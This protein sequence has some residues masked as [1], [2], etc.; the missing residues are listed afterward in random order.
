MNS[1]GDIGAGFSALGRAKGHS[2]GDDG[3][4]RERSCGDT[5]RD[6]S[7]ASPWRTL[8][9]RARLS[10]LYGHR[11]W[12]TI[13]RTVSLFAP[14]EHWRSEPLRIVH[15]FTIPRYWLNASFA[16]A[17]RPFLGRAHGCIRYGRT[18]ATHRGGR[19]KSSQTVRGTSVRPSRM[20]RCSSLNKW[21]TSIP[22]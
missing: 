12:Q 20:S 4:D 3:D 6:D 11:R 1:Y 14:G 17:S 16:P 9:L 10:A 7:S 15:P 22:E 18:A 19:A 21:M 8:G 13:G 5:E 2:T